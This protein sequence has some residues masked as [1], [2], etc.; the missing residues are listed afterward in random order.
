ME[1]KIELADIV[2]E[3]GPAYLAKYHVTAGER[4]ALEA[5]EA[6][7][8]AQLGGHMEHCDSCTYSHPAYNSCRNRH[9]PK[10]LNIAKAHWL[11]DRLDDLLPV[12]YH[13]VVFTIPTEVAAIGKRNPR[14]L[15]N[16]LFKA[17]SQA[18]LRIAR[19]EK[20]LGAKIGFLSVLHTWGQ[21][22]LYHPHVHCVVPAGGL[23]P[24]GDKWVA[25][26]PGFFLPV[27]VLSKIFCSLFLK[28]LGDAHD[29]GQLQ[30]G[31]DD[32]F[33]ASPAGWLDFIRKA[34]STPWVVYSKEPFGGPRQVLSYL[35]RY[36]HRVAIS[37]HRIQSL[38]DG[39]VAFSWRDYSDGNQAKT[40]TLEACEFLRRFLMHVL[41]RGFQRLRYYG[42]LGNRYR[43]A[44]LARCRSLLGVDGPASESAA[45]T[46]SQEPPSLLQQLEEKVAKCPACKIGRL[47]RGLAI[48]PTNPIRAAACGYFSMDSS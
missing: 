4:K 26:R 14:V 13:H 19:D 31:D 48:A 2:R 36:T 40:M 35:G 23:S 6:C 18:M 9:C 5:I 24:E 46:A 20:H 10:C 22:L 8:T 44:N 30:F 28:Y 27:R 33:L 38:V 25:A 15:Y 37:N 1:G 47:Q 43:D 32:G 34:S 41:P 39:K 21:N 29:K 12:A 17:S 42:I 11:N 3:H 7:R 45:D 16:V